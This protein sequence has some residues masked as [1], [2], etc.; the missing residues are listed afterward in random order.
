MRRGPTS[1]VSLQDRPE[2]CTQWG[3]STVTLQHEGLWVTGPC[4]SPRAGTQGEQAGSCVTFP[5]RAM[6]VTWPLLPRP[7]GCKWVRVER[8]ENWPPRLGRGDVTPSL[9]NTASQSVGRSS[10]YYLIQSNNNKSRFK[11]TPTRVEVITQKDC[12][13]NYLLPPR[14]LTASAPRPGTSLS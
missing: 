2:S 6:Q 10:S 4:A 9:E 1:L 8:V 11:Q 3:L 14:T 13:C 7:V 5:D 12:F